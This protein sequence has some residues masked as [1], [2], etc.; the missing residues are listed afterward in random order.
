MGWVVE[1]LHGLETGVASA[2]SATGGGPSTNVFQ[3]IDKSISDGFQVGADMLSKM[4]KRHWYEMP[5]MFFDLLNALIIYVSTL[6][7][8][9]P[10]GAMIV[11]AKAML[12][13]IFPTCVGV[14]LLRHITPVKLFFTFF[15]DFFY[16][17]F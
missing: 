5:M 17:T 11:V 10:A 16:A 9:V 1:A 4:G 7:I 13:I 8:A 6:L 12:S 3:V 2:F 14:F 15:F